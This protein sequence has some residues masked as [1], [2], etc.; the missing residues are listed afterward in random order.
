MNLPMFE[1]VLVNHVCWPRAAHARRLGDAAMIGAAPVIGV[2]EMGTA[3]LNNALRVIDSDPTAR[4]GALR[5][6]TSDGVPY[7]AW[8]AALVNPL[9]GGSGHR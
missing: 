2:L 5:A 8:V 4:R 7:P 9:S 6:A 1:K 3:R